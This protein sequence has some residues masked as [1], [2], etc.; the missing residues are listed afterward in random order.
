MPMLGA[1]IGQCLQE[2][3][4]RTP[5]K[6]AVVYHLQKER[7]T[8]S[9]LLNE[10]DKLAA[11]LLELGIQK[12]DR[13]GIWGPN[14]IEWSLTQYATARIGAILVNIN[15]QYR[16]QELEFALKKVGCKALIS[17]E[18]FRDFD[19]YHMIF[20]LIPELAT[21]KPGATKSHILP[22]LKTIIMMGKTHHP[23]TF[24]MDDVMEAGTSKQRAEI[25]DLQ[26]QLQFDDPINIQFTSGTTGFP[27]GATLTHHNIINNSYFVGRRLEYH[28]RDTRICI[29]VPLYHCFGMVVG[30]LMSIT[31][32]ST[33]VFPSPGFD[34]GLALE[35]VTK[36]RCT[37]LYGVPTMFIDMLN[38]PKFDSF[39]FSSLYTGVM[40]GSPC[41]V[42]TMRQVN[43]KMNMPQVTVCYG[44]TET[45]PVTHQSFMDD[46]IEKRV[47]T[48]GRTHNHVEAKI[49]DENG[50]VVPVNTAGELCTR[51]YTTMLCYWDDPDKTKG[52]IS[53]ERWYHSGDIA[54]M[55]EEG[56]CQIVGRIKDMII[57][58]GEN[59][60]PTEIEQVLYKHADVKDVQ[61]V[62]VPDER[63]GEEIYAFVQ[64]KDGH[65]VTEAD[66]KQFCKEKLARYKVP[67]HV[68][69]VNEFPLTV[70]GKVQ[71]Y[72]L[73]E[74]AT[75][76]LGIS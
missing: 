49:I 20:G 59:V 36:E 9:Q 44:T 27:K 28:C 31:H 66:I 34:A 40:A 64:L 68:E 45:S 22:D 39:D 15:P 69:F 29:P 41:P 12:G 2:Q 58:G 17:A 10:V 11:G 37:S 51:G 25:M 26:D 19:Y 75:K 71:K 3:V 56:F 65:A 13:V 35:A 5:D 60:Y 46:P 4:E 53:T 52:C 76:K 18:R 43:H 54:V 63:L 1:T 73:R 50:K 67:R 14:S 70:T 7:R 42:E 6:E 32:G 23:G 24:R 61:I 74:D 47:S 33:C 21:Q 30:S 38:H 55:D 62:G 57:R 16:P 8:F 72:K 48:I